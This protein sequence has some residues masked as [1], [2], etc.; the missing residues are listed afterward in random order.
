[1]CTR[2]SFSVNLILQVISSVFILVITPT[3]RLLP[4]APFLTEYVVLGALTYCTEEIRDDKY[5]L[6]AN[7]DLLRGTVSVLVIMLFAY[8]RIYTD[9][10]VELEHNLSRLTDCCTV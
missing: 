6:L 7:F 9:T 3:R 1:M 8:Q 5:F 4:F 2:R 10:F